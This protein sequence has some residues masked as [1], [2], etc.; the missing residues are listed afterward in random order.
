MK[1]VGLPAYVR[2]VAPVDPVNA[3]AWAVTVAGEE[4]QSLLQEIY[5]SWPRE[6]VQGK[7]AFARK[8]GINTD[9]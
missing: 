7:E 2:A 6:G 5:N 8:Y 3:E 9:K 1:S 4:R